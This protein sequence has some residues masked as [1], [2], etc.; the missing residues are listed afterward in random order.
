MLREKFDE[1]IR[2]F[3]AEDAGTFDQFIATDLRLLNGTLLIEGRAGMKVHYAKIWS[4]FK[5]SLYVEEFVSNEN[6]LAIQMWAHFD[7]KV[8]N[9][10]SLFG[11]VVVGDQFDFRGLILYKIEDGQFTH[12]T[13]A[14]NSFVHTNPQGEAVNLG[15]VH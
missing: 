14:Y 2:R 13:V 11:P 1:Y 4:T 15:I 9:P 12:I 5:E 6:I 8:N 10:N 7:T 3:N